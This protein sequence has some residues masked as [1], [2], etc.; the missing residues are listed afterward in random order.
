MDSKTKQDIG[1]NT[2]TKSK[3]FHGKKGNQSG[4]IWI[5]GEEMRM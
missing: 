2:T 1:E 3:T 4:V 5:N